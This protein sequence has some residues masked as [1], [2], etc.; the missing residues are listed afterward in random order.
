MIGVLGHGAELLLGAGATVIM[1]SKVESKKQ[2]KQGGRGE[3]SKERRTGGVD[4]AGD[5]VP[6]HS[7][8]VFS[9]RPAPNYC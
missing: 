6:R 4:C 9:R 8:G 5:T 3:K 2:S 7:K 1:P